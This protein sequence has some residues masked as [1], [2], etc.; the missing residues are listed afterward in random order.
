MVEDANIIAPAVL[1][2]IPG[3]MPVQVPMP[4]PKKHAIIKSNIFTPEFILL[5]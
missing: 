1:T 5:I 3:T 4:M 2:C